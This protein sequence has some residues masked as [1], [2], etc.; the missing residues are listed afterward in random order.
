MNSEMHL[1]GHL[2]ALGWITFALYMVAAVLSFRGAIIARA[3]NSAAIGRIWNWLGAILAV[4]GLNKQ[5]DLQT[6]LIEFGRLVARREH[7]YE[8][9]IE[10][11]ALFFLGFIVGIIA[12]LVLLI[13]RL[14]VQIR[15]FGR[16]LP[17]AAIGC[18]L[19]CV[20]IVIRAASIDHVDQMMR[21]D[22]ER[23]PFLWLLEAS[24]L[25]LIIVQALRHAHPA[26]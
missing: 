12:V 15:C 25:T 11:H 6:L 9:R 23:I 20:Y 14:P 16:Q 22:F 8:Y 2:T 17:L 7:L 4:L 19:V 26:H 24:G 13:V 1:A 5:L 3:H 10:L 21:L 18:I